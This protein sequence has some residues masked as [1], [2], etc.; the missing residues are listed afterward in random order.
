MDANPELDE[1]AP[2][3]RRIMMDSD[4]EADEAE[5]DLTPET[6]VAP[7]DADSEEEGEG[8]DLLENIEADYQG[9]EALDNYDTTVLDD[10]EYDAIDVETRRKAEEENEARRGRDEVCCRKEA[11]ARALERILA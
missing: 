1:A 2:K 6:E 5:E 7:P 3:R 11:Q 10:R 4:D 9:I 8:E